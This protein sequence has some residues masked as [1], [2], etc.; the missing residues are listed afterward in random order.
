MNSQDLAMRQKIL[1]LDIETATMVDQ[2][3]KLSD[4]YKP[5]WEKKCQRLS[6][7]L[8]ES[9]ST[10]EEFE[11]IYHDKAAI[12]AEF[13]KVICISV[14]YI[15]K[16]EEGH[17][18]KVKTFVNENESQLLGEFCALL[19]AHYF[20]KQNHFLCGHNIKE[21]DI[22]FICRR[23]LVHDIKL[24]KLL[25][26]MALKSWQTG[27]LL[28]TLDMWKFGDYKHY[29]SLDLLCQ[30][31]NIDSPKSEM[32][33]ADVNEAYWDGRIDEIV[34]YCER[35]LKATTEVYLKMSGLHQ[36]IKL[37]TETI[38]SKAS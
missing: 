31:L 22:P 38:S 19:D 34:R 4:S 12:Y 7:K 1:F 21:F 11:A 23:L 26:I 18:L 20:D 35:D 9:P 24:P 17:N 15:H 16:T 5:H 10:E 29:I 25:N 33:G 36:D 3:A 14:G 27:H 6:Y 37:L 8:E 13:S 30:V 2:Y 28:D 32:S